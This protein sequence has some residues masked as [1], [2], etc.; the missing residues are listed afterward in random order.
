MASLQPDVIDLAA[1]CVG[2]ALDKRSV[3]LMAEV[4]NLFLSPLSAV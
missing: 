1:D 3:D 2:G 4:A